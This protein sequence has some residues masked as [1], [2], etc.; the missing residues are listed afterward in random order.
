MCASGVGQHL[1]QWWG[2]FFSLC[3]GNRGKQRIRKGGMEGLR[4]AGRGSAALSKFSQDF[5]VLRSVVKST[6]ALM[7]ALPSE[8]PPSENGFERC[9]LCSPDPWAGLFF[10]LHS[11]HMLNR[12][13][14]ERVWNAPSARSSESSLITILLFVSISLSDSRM[15]PTVQT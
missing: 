8:S 10:C 2:I 14:A 3:G 11:V 15:A 1:Y 7:I 9:D 13:H 12:K 4:Y 5:P 6:H